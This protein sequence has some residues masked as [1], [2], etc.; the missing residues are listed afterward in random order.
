M[1][2][3]EFLFWSTEIFVIFAKFLDHSSIENSN[4]SGYWSNYQE[5]PKNDYPSESL[6]NACYADRQKMKVFFFKMNGV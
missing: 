6:C 1:S 2:D 3:F 4:D 5:N